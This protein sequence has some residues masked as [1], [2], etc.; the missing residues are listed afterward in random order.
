MN[1]AMNKIFRICLALGC[2]AGIPALSAAQDGR[3]T[4]IDQGWKFHYGTVREAISPDFNDTSWRTLDLPHDWSVE[5][6]AAAQ[7]GENIGPFSKNNPGGSAT[8]Q[9]V[10]G[11]GWYR[12]TFTLSA[13]DEDKRISLYF[14][15]VYAQSEVWVNG[16]KVYFNP[17]GYSSYRFD[18]T[19]YCKPAGEENTVTVRAV[20]EGRNTRWYAGS[21]IY[22]HVWLMKTPEVYLDEWETAIVTDNLTDETAEISVTSTVFNASALSTELKAAVQLLTPDGRQMADA[23]T[24]NLSLNAHDEGDA[25]WTLQVDAPQLWSP[26]APRLYTARILL[27]DGEEATDQIDIPFGIRTLEFSAEKG[28][29]LNGEPT[30]LKGGCVHHDH[31]LLGAASYDR[32]EERK[33]ELL[34]SYGFN[35]VRCSHNIPAESFLDACDRVGLLVI[36]EAFDQWRIAKNPDDYARFF[37]EY[38]ERDLQIMVKRDR[39][40]PSVIMWSIGNEIPGR[41]DDDGVEI[42]RNFREQILRMDA[43]RAVTAGV[44][45]FW[46]KPE[47]SWDNDIWRAFQHLDACGYNYMYGKYESDHARYPD[48]V[49]YGS[50]SYPKQASQNWDLVEKHP[51]VI[52]D[53]VWTAMDYLG[54][55]GIAH[56]LYLN[57][58]EGNPQFMDWP[59]YNGWCGDIDLIGEKKPQSYYRDVLWRIRPI[60]MAVEPPIPSG[61][62]QAISGWGWQNERV[63]WTFP[64][65]TEQDLMTVN[66][67][68]RAPQ[69]RLYLNGELVGEKAVSDTYWAG[70]SVPYRPGT[71]K[72]VE[73]DG[74]NEGESF[75]LETTGEPVGIRLRADRTTIT[76][77]GTDL[78]YIVAELVDAEGQ[79][80]QTDDR[81][82]SFS[83]TGE[84]ILLASG[85]AAPDDMES[86]RSASPMLFGGK[87]LAILKS[88]GKPGEITLTVSCDGFN[89]ATL[90]VKT[91]ETEP[92]KPDALAPVTA[93]EQD[94]QVYAANRRI[95][96]TGTDD[97]HIYNSNGMET[98]R[99]AALAAG[100]YL[101]RS[102]SAVRKVI[103]K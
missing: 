61:Q 56:A 57:N 82:V 59:W 35:A 30:K 51:Y 26:E 55:A 9:T 8:G 98:N 80:V 16:I 45:D 73:W 52:G 70:F 66:V 23:D 1:T 49:M 54:E 37:D 15:G 43:T 5:T 88:T 40:H 58:G 6:E 93:Q 34:K 21:G 60:T 97:Y 71:L 12:K 10:G 74:S 46:D 103:V 14:E 47:F 33:A 7:A 76:S 68:T 100:V 85:N 11:E 90:N 44:N 67:Y 4:C 79:V 19:D 28:F 38:S 3:K 53:F 17:Y 92:E 63:D 99:N 69:V 2:L 22:R 36:D 86:F 48:R 91:T 27:L 20:N 29:L 83:C 50:E 81:K 101:V 72:A 41:A 18:I 24:V 39:N 94:F 96:V 95:H 64:G 32:A 31:G 65:Y 13:A 102:G 78:A 25:A 62:W 87:A 77:N 84:G 42:A 89:D 75:E